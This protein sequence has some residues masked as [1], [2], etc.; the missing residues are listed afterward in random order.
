MID[1]VGQLRDQAIQR[2]NPEATGLGALTVRVFKPQIAATPATLE[3]Q[4]AEHIQHVLK[5]AEGN[6]TQAARMLGIDRVSLWR[7]LK[8]LGIDSK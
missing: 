3:S 5:L 8:K 7:K 1:C 4:E 6:P 2:V